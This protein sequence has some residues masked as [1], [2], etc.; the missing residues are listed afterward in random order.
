MHI[1]KN[2]GQK[3]RDFSGIFHQET[4]DLSTIHGSSKFPVFIYENS[5]WPEQLEKRGIITSSFP[6]PTSESPRINRIVI[7]GFHSLNDLM[8][9]N[10]SLHQLAE[11]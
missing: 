11:R 10:D 4:Q 5:A 8:F 3:I 6:Y 7:S 9:L 2:Q 1:Y